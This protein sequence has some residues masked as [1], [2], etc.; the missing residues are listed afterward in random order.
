MPVLPL[1]LLRS[2]SFQVGLTPVTPVHCGITIATAVVTPW[3][4]AP[5]FRPTPL[6]SISTTTTASLP[7]SSK[8][9]GVGLLPTERKKVV[10]KV[11]WVD[12]VKR[13]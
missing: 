1:Q 13:G 10:T 2:L 7:G 9:H 6:L 3:N 8:S 5:S 12:D 11:P 4:P